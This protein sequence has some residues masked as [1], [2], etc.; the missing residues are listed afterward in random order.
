[1]P[2]A[3]LTLTLLWAAAV[4]AIPLG[5]RPAAVGFILL[6]DLAALGF[7]FVPALVVG[8]HA[9]GVRAA[10]DATPQSPIERM[11]VRVATAVA[12]SVVAGT[13]LV[14]LTG[15]PALSTVVVGVLVTSVFF[16]LLAH[17]ES[18]GLTTLTAFMARVPGWGVLLIAPALVHHAGI[19][20]SAILAVSPVT[21]QLSLMSGAGV[22]WVQWGWLALTTLILVWRA[23]RRAARPTSLP[24]D[25]RVRPHRD[26]GPVN[27]GPV[28][29]VRSFARVDRRLV[30]RDP[31]LTLVLV[32][33]PLMAILARVATIGGLGWFEGRF[34]ID[35]RPYLPLLW[36]FAVVVHTPIVLGALTGLLLLEDRD[37][38]LWPSLATT[39]TGL[40]GVVTYRCSAAALGSIALVGAGLAIVGAAHDLGWGGLALTAVASGAIAP[41]TAMAMATL[42]RDRAQ[43]IAVMK[44]AGLVLYLPL[45]MWMLDDGWRVVGLLIPSG[46]ALS[47]FWASDY[48]GAWMTL[49]GSV[50]VSVLLWRL[51]TRRVVASA[52]H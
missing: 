13:A 21:S 39:P 40:I 18:S 37:A 25:H 34:G 9:Q 50:V 42:A 38:G 14:L 16:C 46:W 32:G 30:T 31:L 41:V 22:G 5:A 6:V 26:L 7:F 51:M 15:V 4:R 24:G 35:A 2:V 12:V 17:A 28:R 20:D 19:W 10:L 33:V 8:E 27:P 23:S 47:T 52:V 43:G 3:A 44:V 36:G 45:G 1:M 29:A 48:L 11:A 49:T